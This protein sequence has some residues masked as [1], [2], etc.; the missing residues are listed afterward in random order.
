MGLI[1]ASAAPHRAEGVFHK[2][3]VVE[4]THKAEIRPEE[5]SEKAESGRDKDP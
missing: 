4:R 3:I 5:Q 2:E 1:S